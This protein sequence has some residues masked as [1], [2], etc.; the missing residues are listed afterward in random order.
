LLLLVGFVSPVR[1]VAAPALPPNVTS[2]YVRMPQT[3]V[4]GQPLRVV[5]ALHGI[6]GDGLTFAS[7]LTASADRYGWV[8]VAPTIAYGNWMDPAQ[9]A[10][11]DPQLV[12]WLSSYLAQLRAQSNQPLD[13]TVMLLGFSR[14]AQLAHRFAEA[15][16]RQTLAV[17]AASAGS[18]TLPDAVAPDGTP[19]PFPYG[20]ADFPATIGQVFA[21][22]QLQSVHF[23]IGVGNNDTNPA[24]V[25]QQFD[26]YQGNDRLDRAR[27]F[28]AA[29]DSL[30]VSA[31]LA[32]FPD[33]AHA[34]TPVMEQA[35]VAF[36]A[37]QPA[38]AA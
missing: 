29:L 38:T 11:E 5:V 20:L 24:D 30:N 8:L 3:T 35:A 25:P 37:A 36:L 18:Y 27:A 32:V 26:S 16:P 4:P 9:V 28:V 33:V 2:V 23:W 6:G 10:Q 12:S 1:A 14:G 34:F 13:P 7:D 19:L 17:A 21:P 22:A 15:Y 31:Q